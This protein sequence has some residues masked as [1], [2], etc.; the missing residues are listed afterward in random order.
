MIRK[1]KLWERL[2][3]AKIAAIYARVSSRKQKEGETIESQLDSLRQFARKQ[4]YVIPKGFEFKDAGYSGAV[5]ERPGLD[6][7]RDAV[8]DNVLDVVLIYSTDRLSRKY[9]YQLLLQEE[10]Q[11]RKVEVQFL[12][13]PSA[14]TP[15]EQFALHFQGVFAEYERA[16]IMERSR[17]GR[18]Y[19]A[20]QGDASVLPRIPYGYKRFKNGLKTQ[21]EIDETQAYLIR[22]IF[23]LYTVECI[24]LKGICRELESKGVLTPTNLTKW[25]PKTIKGFLI[26]SAYIGMA[27]YGKTEKGESISGRIVRYKSGRLKTARR[28][29]AHKPK[30]TWFEIPFPRI[31]KNETFEK[32]QALLKTNKELSKRNTKEQSLLQGLLVCEACGN[33]YWKKMRKS[34]STKLGYYCCRSQLVKA[35]CA[36]DNRSIRVEKMDKLIW[37]NL[38]DL[39]KDPHLVEQE[40]SRRIQERPDIVQAKRK[41]NE[42]ERVLDRMKKARDKLLDAYQSGDC[43]SLEELRKRMKGIAQQIS[44]LESDLRAIDAVEIQHN[45]QLNIKEALEHFQKQI[46]KNSETLNVTEKQK[47]V[48]LLID[49]VVIGKESIKIKHCIPL[50]ISSRENSLLKGVGR[51]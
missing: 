51:G 40:I 50:N 47:I 43:L 37:N 29:K 8:H 26:N 33:A 5:L 19:K 14:T 9:A 17:R 22:E 10:F 45:E 2:K 15:E 31:I 24:S 49:E 34:G 42:I 16:Q 30:D 28:P 39:L 27:H 7:L 23:N 13:S 18:L 41:R 35:L 6:A 44:D 46:N 21:I 20:K 12:K 25:D 4:G 11:K 1:N 36:C 32:A 48:R 3:M 38:L